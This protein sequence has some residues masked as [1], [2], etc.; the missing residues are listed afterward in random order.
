MFIHNRSLGAV[1][2]ALALSAALA[3]AGFVARGNAAP[4]L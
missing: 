3:F 4:V 2:A 1:L